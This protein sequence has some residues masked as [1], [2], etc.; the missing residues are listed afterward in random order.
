VNSHRSLPWGKP[1]FSLEK[2][3][4]GEEQGRDPVIP[5]KPFKSGSRIP[6]RL[7]S[8]NNILTPKPTKAKG[9]EADTA[10]GLLCKTGIPYRVGRTHFQN[11]SYLFFNCLRLNAKIKTWAKF[12]Q[13]LGKILP[14]GSSRPF[15]GPTFSLHLAQNGFVGDKGAV[16]T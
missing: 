13:C 7:K 2:Q 15:F 11:Y 14:H 12:P 10:F 9:G 3:P 8:A 6:R 16:L 4:R 5:A 1:G